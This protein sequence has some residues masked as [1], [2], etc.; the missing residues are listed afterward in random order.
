MLASTP[1]VWFCSTAVKCTETYSAQWHELY[2]FIYIYTDK[3]AHMY[4]LFF[5]CVLIELQVYFSCF[6]SVLYGIPE[7]LYFK[8]GSVQ[9]TFLSAALLY[10]SLRPQWLPDRPHRLFF[11][12]CLYNQVFSETQLS[13][14]WC[15]TGI[16]AS[17]RQI[18]CASDVTMNL[19]NIVKNPNMFGFLTFLQGRLQRLFSYIYGTVEPKANR[20]TD[21]LLHFPFF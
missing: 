5:S 15:K 9:V 3:F 4:F 10:I 8:R 11:S 12:P 19:A 7:V 18:Q 1:L 17:L 14:I 20:H 6:F 13:T 21:I 16:T 2:I